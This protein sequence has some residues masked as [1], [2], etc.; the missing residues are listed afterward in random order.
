MQVLSG[1]SGKDP[2][3]DSKGPGENSTPKEGLNILCVYLDIG[4]STQLNIE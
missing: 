1:S 3:K 4:L 2:G